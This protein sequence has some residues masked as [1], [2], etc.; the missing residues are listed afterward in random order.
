MWL[1]FFSALYV[2]VL[3]NYPVVW[4]KFG[5]GK[6]L[7]YLLLPFT[8]YI[9]GKYILSKNRHNDQLYL[10]LLLLALAIG[11]MPMTSV[12]HDIFAHGFAGGSR[13]IVLLNDTGSE[14]SATGIDGYLVILASL[15]GLLVYRSDI[16]LE[17]SYKWIL[18][19]F[20]MLS[21]FCILRT[22]TRTGIGII[23]MSILVVFIYNLKKHNF[24]FYLLLICSVYVFVVN[25]MSF[26]SPFFSY[27][28]ER[29]SEGNM[30]SIGNRAPLW[31]YYFS[32]LWQYPWG[33]IPS[34]FS[35]TPFAHNLWLDVGRLTGIL[36]FILLLTFNFLA[37]RVFNRFIKN[38]NSPSLY[39][40]VVLIW[41]V[42]IYTVFFVEP[43]MEGLFS[44]FVF[45]CFLVGM[46]KQSN[47][48]Y[49][50]KKLNVKYFKKI[51]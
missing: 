41:H 3:F 45:Y 31:N 30:G 38:R 28:T 42:A 9:C 20:S 35:Y 43:V 13:N 48:I 10:W 44:L 26:L 5:I 46:Q 8:A 21:I 16:K 47:Y 29:T 11:I 17:K 40:N 7:S 25:I 23:G 6:M 36:P 50:S 33:G 1:L 39:R 22:G 12:L 51:A 24:L 27:L 49:G 32:H 19:L 14:R 15:A 37:L 18:I 2:I 34:V 4:Q